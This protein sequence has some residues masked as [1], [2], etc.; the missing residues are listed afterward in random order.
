MGSLFSAFKAL[1]R[2]VS[3]QVIERI[4]TPMNGGF[5]TISLRLKQ[6]SSSGDYY[7]VLAELSSGN[8]QYAAFTK[9]EFGEFSDAVSRIQKLLR[10]HNL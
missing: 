9:E 1:K 10:E 8:Y 7:V 4:D 3:G 2:V 5:T 6:E